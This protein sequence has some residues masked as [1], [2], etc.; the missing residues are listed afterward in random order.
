MRTYRHRTVALYAYVQIVKYA[1]FIHASRV[2]AATF[3]GRSSRFA[4][5][6]INRFKILRFRA[7]DFTNL[8]KPVWRRFIRT[9]RY[10]GWW[11]WVKPYSYTVSA[12]ACYVSDY[13]QR[14][15]KYVLWPALVTQRHRNTVLSAD[16]SRTYT[17]A[18]DW[19]WP[20]LLLRTACYNFCLLLPSSDLHGNTT[21][22]CAVFIWI[23]AVPVN[24]R[25][26]Y[27]HQTQTMGNI[28]QM[29]AMVTQFTSGPQTVY[30]ICTTRPKQVSG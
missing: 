18:A 10:G 11:K 30:F 7:I 3:L 5:P 29:A 28:S 15:T 22:V 24:K 13:R 12:A 9:N 1:Y 19:A 14:T 26:K 16:C 17:K 25:E 4:K 2:N 8:S 20:S 23:S 27:H 21:L 6:N